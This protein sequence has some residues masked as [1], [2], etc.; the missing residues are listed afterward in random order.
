MR[1]TFTE[2]R[3]Q[4]ESIVIDMFDNIDLGEVEMILKVMD[5]KIK[6]HYSNNRTPKQAAG[7]INFKA[8]KR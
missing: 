3:K 2:Y 5:Y 1:N 7:Y 8:W 6:R 4:I